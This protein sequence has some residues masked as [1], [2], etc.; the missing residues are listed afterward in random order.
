MIKRVYRMLLWIGARSR[1]SQ[2]R[3]RIFDYAPSHMNITLSTELLCEY[4]AY[5]ARCKVVQ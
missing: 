3:G 4:S 5:Y 1:C 2:Y